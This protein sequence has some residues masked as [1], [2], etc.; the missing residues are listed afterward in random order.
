MSKKKIQEIFGANADAY[1]TSQVHAQGASLPRLVELL[2]PRAEWQVL[3]VATGGGHTAFVLAP[4]VANVI[5]SDL[6][7]EMLRNAAKGAEERGL[8]N[9][10]AETADAEQLP[11]PD[12]SFDCV[13]CRIAAHHFPDNGRFLSE[14]ARVL[15]PGGR[16]ALV[17]NVVPG[18]HLRGKKAKT[19]RQVGEYV[20]AFEKLRDPSHVRALSVDEWLNLFVD[21]GFSEIHQETH[22]K[23]MDFDTW[24]NR[25]QVTPENRMRLKAMLLQSPTAV[26]DFLTPQS[27]GDRIAFYLTE[28]IIIGRSAIS[29]VSSGTEIK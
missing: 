18:S 14:C 15:K 20:N 1:V 27:T 10:A 7:T 22:R 17:D 11:F 12:G 2:A 19:Q 28:A 3:D 23:K 9:V 21:A 8:T 6:T 13:T 26:A 4:H 24:T 25:M 16:M 29:H 5:A